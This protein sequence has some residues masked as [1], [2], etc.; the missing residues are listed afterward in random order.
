MLA[1][2]VEFARTVG[3]INW[4]DGAR[5]LWKG[6]MYESLVP[7]EGGT[8]AAVLNRGQPHV[9]RVASIF[10]LSDG[11]AVIDECHLLAAKALWD[12]SVRCARY[13]FGE[14]LGDPNAEKILNALKD[15]A[16]NGMTRTEIS[17]DVF[18]RNLGSPRIQSSLVLLMERGLIEERSE[19]TKGRAACRYFSKAGTN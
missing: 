13:I 4:S 7:R 12:A 3:R 17:V 18:R 19:K 8:L 11:L 9:L 5:R 6:S 16:P 15:A 10:A 14:D 2:A 1:K